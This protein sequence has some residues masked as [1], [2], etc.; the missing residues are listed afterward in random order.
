MHH[1]VPFRNFVNPQAANQLDNLITL[2]PA[3]HQRAETRVRMRSGLSGLGY[4]LHHLAPLYLMCDQNDLGLHVDPESP[5]TNG[6][7]AIVLYDH[8]PDGIGLS[9]A[10][11]DLHHTLL[12]SAQDLIQGCSCDDGCPSCIGPAGEQGIGGKLETLA[13]I[14]SLLGE[15][16]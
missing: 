12:K 5:F 11:F 4:I 15:Q 16:T 7:P 1:I 9:E 14:R 2:C 3:C 6:N 8:I 13:L 10:I